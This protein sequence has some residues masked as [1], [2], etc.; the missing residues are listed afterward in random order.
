MESDIDSRIVGRNRMRFSRMGFGP[1]ALTIL[2]S[3][4]RFFSL[5]RAEGG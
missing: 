1:G 3:L 5:F 4:V 2:I